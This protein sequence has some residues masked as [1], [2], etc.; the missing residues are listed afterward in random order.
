MGITIVIYIIVGIIIAEG[1]LKE[2]MTVSSQAPTTITM[3]AICITYALA[4]IFWLPV[5]VFTTIKGLRKNGKTK[6]N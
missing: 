4:I 5:L 1:Y 3:T 6:S 2:V